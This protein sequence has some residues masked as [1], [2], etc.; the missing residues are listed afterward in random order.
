MKIKVL[1]KTIDFFEH[2]VSDKKNIFVAV[3]AG[4]DSTITLYLTAL[5]L[6]DRKI[7][8]YHGVDSGFPHLKERMYTI[9]HELNSILPNSNINYP[10]YRDFDVSIGSYWRNEAIKNPGKLPKRS[11][12]NEGQAKILAMREVIKY[13]K[14]NHNA[15]YFVHGSTSNPPIEVT[16]TWKCEVEKRRNGHVEPY[17]GNEFYNPFIHLNKKYIAELYRKFKIPE[18]IILLT[19]SCVGD[20]EVS[21]WFESPCM[22]CYW[23]HE[24]KWAFGVY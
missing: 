9:V 18:D 1:D 11:K 24:K 5:Y 3:S 15:D 2:D 19:I 17:I 10:I 20:H 4:L 6:S 22:K 13:L 12:G 16:R 23:C 8:T 14:E 21:N 7:N